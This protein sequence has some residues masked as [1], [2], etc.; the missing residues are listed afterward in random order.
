MKLSHYTSVS[1]PVCR[2]TNL[3]LEAIRSASRHSYFM[4]TVQHVCVF[5]LHKIINMS[6]YLHR[7]TFL[8]FSNIFFLVPGV[9]RG[10]HWPNLGCES[11]S[12]INTLI[13]AVL[14]LSRHSAGII[15]GRTDPWRWKHYLPSGCRELTIKRGDVISQKNEVYLC[16]ELFSSTLLNNVSRNCTKFKS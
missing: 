11:E 2:D 3:C 5:P 6:H 14:L 7:L 12:L 15:L 1:Q 4:M 10:S 16:H 8:Y 9:A 13:I